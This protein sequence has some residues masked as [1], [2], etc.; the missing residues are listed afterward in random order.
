[1]FSKEQLRWAK[2]KVSGEEHVTLVNFVT[3]FKLTDRLLAT[4][5][6]A[7]LIGSEEIRGRR[8]EKLQESFHVFQAH[9][10][11]TFWSERRLE[12]SSEITANGAA[13]DLQAAAAAQSRK[14]YSKL[15]SRSTGAEF[16]SDIPAEEN[17]GRLPAE[18]NKKRQPNAFLGTFA[19]QELPQQKKSRRQQEQH[20]EGNQDLS[21]H[22]FF[23]STTITLSDLKIQG[24]DVGTPF[25]RLQKDAATIVNDLRITLTLDLLPFFLATNYIWDTSHRLP[26]IASA[27]HDALQA[28]RV[29]VIH[30]SDHLVLFCRS[31]ERDILSSGYIKSRDTA[32]RE[33]DAMLGL[34][35][36]ASLKLPRKFL[37]FK[38]FKNEDT[39]AHSALDALL[40]YIF[41]ANSYRYDLHWA[42]RLSAGSSDRRNGDAYKPDATVLKDGFEMGYLEIKPP[43]EERHQRLYLEDIWTL[44]G[45]AKDNIDLH[46]RCHRII[47]TVPCVM[48]FGFQMT[49]YQLSFQ[50]GIYAWRDVHT[51]YLPKDH[52]DIGNIV[53]CV[54]LLN[55]FKAILD[56]AETERYTRTPPRH[57]KE[58][59]ELPESYR[60]RPTTLT[61]SKRPFF[62]PGKRMSM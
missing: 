48:V 10:A 22:C 39:H 16:A 6:Y 5:A 51:A 7:A 15:L 37:S 28:L 41:P 50:D 36:Q 2:V 20:Q 13:L 8:R 14:G 9:H 57:A 45:F 24:I 52:Y 58:D 61:P 42:N 12:V 47:T 60:P 31:L 29:P 18:S 38:H 53:S 34:F 55:T 23:D 21:I 11:D 62:G 49:L 35:Q 3:E 33:H 44:V 54:E 26:G 25:M 1:M 43:K 27:D 17:A 30:L 46:F 32:S 56:E 59:K 4:D 19:D 40:T